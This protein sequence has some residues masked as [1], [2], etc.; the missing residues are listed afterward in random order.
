ME[1][2]ES[3][4]PMRVRVVDL[5]GFRLCAKV[6]ER[7]HKGAFCHLALSAPENMAE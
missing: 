1:S 7:I 3:S 6:T 2:E 5:S 4:H